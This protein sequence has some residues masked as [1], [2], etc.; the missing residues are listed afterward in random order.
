MIKLNV[1]DMSCNHCI[2]VIEGAVK[3]LDAAAGINV[4]LAGKTVTIETTAGPEAV[5]QALD[6]AGYPSSKA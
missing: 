4:D 5:S 3:G 6:A 1:P 2:K